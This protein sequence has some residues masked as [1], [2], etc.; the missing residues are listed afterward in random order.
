[1]RPD[2]RS[3]SEI[4]NNKQLQRARVLAIL[5][6]SKIRTINRVALVM[7]IK[8]AITNVSLHSPSCPGTQNEDEASL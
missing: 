8:Q 7:N 1:M 4:S 2:M 6:S 3:T 5:R